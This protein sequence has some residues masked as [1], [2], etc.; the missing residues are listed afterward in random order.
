MAYIA[1]IH[2][3]S[4]VRH[5]LHVKLLSADEESLIIAKSNRLEIW[6]V[7]GG[8]LT[9]IHSKAIFGTI[10]MLQKLRPKDS[11]T[12]LLFVG[13]GRQQFFTASWD[14]QKNDLKTV[15]VIIDVGERHMRDS[16]SQDRALVDPSGRYLALHLWEGVLTIEKLRM[17]KGNTLTLEHLEQVRLSELF[18]KASTFLYTETGHPKIAFLYQT[19]TETQDSQLATYRLTSD[20]R[21]S[22]ASK[23]DAVRDRELSMDFPDPGAAMLIP[24]RK[25]EEETKRHNVR[26]PTQAKAHLGGL[27]LVGE[28]RLLYIDDVTKATVAK[29]LQA[30]A[31]FVAWAEYDA[32]HYFLG[33]DYGNMYLLTLVC[34]GV[35]VESLDVSYIGKTSRASNLVYLGDNLLFVASHYGDSQVYRVDLVSETDEFL[36]L[37]QVL[38]NISPIL[39][40]AVMDMGNREGETESHMGN[41]YSSGQA[42][43]VTGSGVYKDGTLR[44]VRSGVGLDDIGIL[45]DLEDVRGLF[46]MRSHGSE[47]VDT[48]VASFLTETRIFKFDPSGEVEEVDSFNGFNF[49]HQTLLAANLANGRLLQVTTAGVVLVD[50]E[51]GVQISSWNP[52]EGKAVTNAS[53]NE[54]WL[55]LSVDGTSLM[56]LDLHELRVSAETQIGEKDQV[57]C[58]HA[59]P[60][61]EDVGVVGFWASATVTLVRMSTLQPIHGTKLRRTEDEASIPRDLALVQILPPATSGPTLFVAMEDGNVHTFNISAQDL[62]LSGRKTVVLGTRQ[63]SLQL[64][65]QPSGVYN[66]FATSE[67]SSLIHGSEGRIVYSAVTAEDATCACPFDTEAYPGCIAL[68]TESQ[69]KIAEIDEERRT[70]VR[71]LEMGE[72]VRR[73]AY[74]P[75][76]KVFGLG[77]IKRSLVQGEEI[78]QSSFRLVD[79]VIF[80]PLG[81]PFLLNEVASVVELVETVIRAEL[82][83][84]YGNPSER[85]IVGTSYLADPDLGH[86]SAGQG[87]ILVFGIDSDRSPYLIMRHELKGSCR[88]LEVMDGQIVAALTKTVVVFHYEETSNTSGELHRLASYRPAT[89]PVDLAVEGNLIAVADLQKSVVLVEYVPGTDGEDPKLVPRSRHHQAVWATSVAHVEGDSWLEADAQGNLMVLR[90]NRQGL[91]EEQR[92]RMEMTSEINLGEMV[93]KIRKISVE[94]SPN[95]VMVPKAFLGT[96][97]GAI[98]M[99]GIIAPDALDLLMRFQSNLAPFV[100]APGITDDPNDGQSSIDFNTYRSFRNAEREGDGPF[101]FVDGEI[102]ERFLDVD[103]QTQQQICEGLGPSV[104]AMR[105]MV[106][107]LRRMH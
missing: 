36:Q 59:A 77:C 21:D 83:D 25:V 85:F 39:D 94:T 51:S 31:I 105:N 102:I 104:E 47:K 14:P 22:V 43:I 24:V 18:V 44:S 64:L 46:S 70:H 30:A 61:L 9:M 66:I 97:E 20:D 49:D 23:F 1:P 15:Q 6:R 78:V 27:V 67:H 48:L 57:A 10:T 69:I 87:R 28:T 106:E 99:F 50:G 71:P 74:S 54:K 76:E 72:T 91:T 88:C 37:V 45:A 3:A 53:A 34:E 63:A 92:Q 89:Y 52:E 62:T 5:A 16:Q 29:A 96:V 60:R 73:I 58:V 100:K 107:E 93:N 80:A 13:T 75:T 42:R 26:N 32:T 101:R 38:P 8:A 33:D 84:A 55:L 7:A 65:P 82:P 11:P 98:Y 56:S 90:Y 35:V 12:D 86:N 17:R 19:D 95:A 40:F 81:K 4:S 79:D 2:R 68:A 41:A 103:D